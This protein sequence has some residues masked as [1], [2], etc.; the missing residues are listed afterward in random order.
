[1]I[2]ALLVS[3]DSNHRER[4]ALYLRQRDIDL[5]TA[6]N[7]VQAFAS[8]WTEQSSGNPFRAVIVDQR[9]LDMD[10]LQFS[11]SVAAERSLSDLALLLIAPPSTSGHRQQLL[12]SG[13]RRILET[14]VNE[15]HLFSVL[16]RLTRRSLATADVLDL[17][18][19]LDKRDGG[20]RPQEILVVES[21]EF[22][23]RSF[24]RIL[25]RAGHFVYSVCNGE[26]ALEALESHDLD[27]V[28]VSQDMQEMSGVQLA[29]L[30]HFSRSLRDWIPFI[31]VGTNGSIDLV[32]QCEDARV[33]AFLQKPIDGPKLI[34]T[35]N[36]VL[37]T[38]RCAKSGEQAKEGVVDM[39]CAPV[40][41]NLPLLEGATLDSLLSLRGGADFVAQL[42][43]RFQTDGERLIEKM[44]R[45]LEQDDMVAFRDSSRCLMDN[46][47]QI[48]ALAI[49]D[50]SMIGS[51]IGGSTPFG[52][53]D[54]LIK[55]IEERF[56]DTCEAL[57]QFLNHGTL[58]RG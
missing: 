21:S 18:A 58:A 11:K 24:S 9:R 13:F 10:A 31:V 37:S 16:H 3:S 2:H 56:S 22:A 46:S 27:L 6:N 4:I 47:G 36:R 26:Q 45:A 35:I 34:E 48:G 29:K 1:M 49:H 15:T 23:R 28:V 38:N 50:C 54:T 44:K 25:E 19:R 32:K 43:E 14:P 5:D 42:A 40:I 12:A 33:S 7:S 20:I 55:E 17:S 41:A 30:H 51:R 57:R 39:R 8:I 52:A 53:A